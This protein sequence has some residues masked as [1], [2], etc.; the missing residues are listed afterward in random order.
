MKI[1]HCADWNTMFV[2]R[3][4][5]FAIKN[6]PE[7]ITCEVELWAYPDFK[8]HNIQPYQEECL[9]ILEA[10]NIPHGNWTVA[11][12]KTWFPK[13]KIITLCSDTI[14]WMVHGGQQIADQHLIDLNLELMPNAREWMDKKGWKNDS[15]LWTCSDIDIGQ[16]GNF[17]C[18]SE[19][20]DYQRKKHDLI[21]LLGPWTINNPG[22][23]HDMVKWL[24]ENGCSFIQGG[25]GNHQDQDI[26]YIYNNYMDSWLNLGTSSHGGAEFSNMGCLKGWREWISPFLNCL[27]IHDDHPNIQNAY[28]KDNILPTYRYG[29][30]D[31]IK[32]LV[33]FYKNNLYS[34]AQKLDYQ[35]QWA[36][37]NTIDKQ[38]TRLLV[39]HN[40][41]KVEDVVRDC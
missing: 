36:R 1:F 41:I 13:C 12:L 11:E 38:L 19:T 3:T 35:R 14:Y 22:Y 23:R 39:K 31:E 5:A 9:L 15:W 40:F 20:I 37:E 27:L 4:L 16:I 6:L 26:T 21:S 8:Q 17:Y 18:K 28:N 10:G 29:H 34:Y 33:Y 25:R 30:F 32:E 24:K 7:Y 2:Y